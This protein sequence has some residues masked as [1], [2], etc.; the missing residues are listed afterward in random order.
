[1]CADFVELSPKKFAI[2]GNSPILCGGRMRPASSNGISILAAHVTSTHYVLMIQRRRWNRGKST[3]WWRVARKA[4]GMLTFK[5][6]RV[7]HL[8]NSKGRRRTVKGKFYI[9]YGRGDDVL[10]QMANMVEDRGRYRSM[11]E[12]WFGR[13]EIVHVNS[14]SPH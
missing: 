2:L 3:T 7:C 13:F 5:S 14:W 4:L 6:C 1:M 10:T 11:C 8:L 12:I 9:L